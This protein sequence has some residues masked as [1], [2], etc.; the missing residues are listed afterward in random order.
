MTKPPVSQKGSGVR[1][2]AIL[3]A[4]IAILYLAREILIPLVFAIVLALVLSPA[5]AWLQKLGLGRLP[6]VLFIMLVS[7]ATAGGVAGS[8]LMSY[9][10]W[11][12]IFP[13]TSRTF[14]TRFKPSGHPAKALSDGLP[15]A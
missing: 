14:I 1:T 15:P 9:W 5:V 4:V 7:I 13:V 10:K 6:S 12:T 2:A 8:F 3:V 11:S